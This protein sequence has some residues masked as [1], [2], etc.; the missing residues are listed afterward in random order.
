MK[1]IT[2][3]TMD[4]A[5]FSPVVR[6]MTISTNP[7]EGQL[8]DSVSLSDV[9]I[10]CMNRA[11]DEFDRLERLVQETV[12]PSLGGYQDARCIALLES[13]EIIR[14]TTCNFCW[15]HRYAGAAEEAREVRQ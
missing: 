4:Q 5:S 1:N 8:L 14:M 6:L 7:L 2:T 3:T 9:D 15:K 13:L 12:L 10:V 11:R